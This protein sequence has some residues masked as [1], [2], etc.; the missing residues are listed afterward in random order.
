MEIKTKL[1]DYFGDTGKAIK[2]AQ[3]P[4]RVNLIGEHT[5]YNDGFV[6]PIAIDREIKMAAQARNDQKVKV[7]SLDFKTEE[8]FKVN[9]IS[10]NQESNWINY[11]QGVA[12]M[13]LD[14]GYNLTGMNLI[15]TGNI[16]RGAGLSSSAALEV[17]TAVILELVNGFKLD[18][19][20]L[21]KLCQKAENDFVGVS[22]GIMDQFISA[23]GKKDNALFIDCRS[24]DYQLVPMDIAEAKIVISNTN[25][26]HSLVDSAYN[27]RLNEC[28]TAVEKFQQFLEKDL[29]A[30]RDVTIS[31][32]KEH[33]S[34]LSDLIRKRARHVIYE[35]KRVKKT[36]AAL[37]AGRLKEVGELMQ[38]SHQS[39]SNLYDVSCKELD[40]MVELALEIDGVLGSRMT[41]AGFG[42]CTVSLVKSNAVEEFKRKV[43]QRYFK[44][45][46]IE[47]DIYVCNIEAG[48]HQLI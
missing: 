2:V 8:S 5:D 17:A 42:G 47:T 22:C 10:Y 18:R 43:S 37:K 11:I 46:G 33:K 25:V 24:N 32:F 35:N 39:L 16:P 27:Q 12:K 44:Q 23:L 1:L 28:Q 30:L 19:V 40:I 41:G 45:T 15:L 7:Y 3:A 36:V 20:K 26:E 9:Q 4:G 31:E 14:E 13:I 21:A 48:A 6:L 34:K 29:T 38:Q